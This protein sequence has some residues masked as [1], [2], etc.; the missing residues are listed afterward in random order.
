MTVTAEDNNPTAPTGEDYDFLTPEE[1][2]NS[3]LSG[4]IKAFE[5]LTGQFNGKL[6]GF[7]CRFVQDEH[8][9]EDVHQEVLVKIAVHAHKYDGRAKLSTWIFQIA[10]NSALDA[11][12]KRKRT[13]DFSASVD[14][15][16]K[17]T[18][19]D[20]I[21]SDL[22]PDTKV[23]VAELGERI[24]DAVM[25]LPDDQR[26]VFLMRE[27]ADLSFD[28]IAQILGCNKETVKS[29]MRYAVEKLRNSLKAEAKLYG[30][31]AGL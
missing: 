16:E 9:A 29:R 19:E 12:R 14:V 6:Y 8:L 24:S 22:T 3:Y 26:E 21:S 5:V 1:L 20:A 18:I 27:D 13:K 15:E 4:N 17:H 31:L 25:R 11:I 2:L 30:L 7:L 28:E 10:R 23:T